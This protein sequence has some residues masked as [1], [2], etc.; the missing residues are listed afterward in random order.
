MAKKSIC[1]QTPFQL[2]VAAYRRV[3]KTCRVYS[4]IDKKIAVDIWISV[5]RCASIAILR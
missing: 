1:L 4:L 3:A 2:I 5:L